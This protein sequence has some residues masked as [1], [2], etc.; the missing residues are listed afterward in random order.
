VIPQFQSLALAQGPVAAYRWPGPAGAPELHFAHA[1]G[2]NAFTYRHLL[3][4]LADE[5]SVVATD[6]RGHGVTALPAVPGAL[7]SWTLYASDLI[8]V[9]ERLGP[10]PRILVG[11]SLG[12]VISLFS[13]AT[14]PD[15]A[16]AVIM[17][18]PVTTTR[19]MRVLWRLLR[20]I[21]LL[22]PSPLTQNTLRRRVIWNSKD[23]AFAAYRGR[24]AFRTWPEEMLRDYVE[25]GLVEDKDGQLRLACSPE[26]EAANYRLGP[27]PIL[28]ALPRVKCPVTILHGTRASTV[29]PPIL[30]EIRRRHKGVRLIE[31]PRASHFLPMEAPEL[32]RGEIRRVAASVKPTVQL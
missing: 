24:G 28:D 16:S 17:I 26:W 21:G 18:E 27:P 13:A 15:L 7:K 3:A 10:T 12:A 2:F 1:N 6:F 9:L 22:G 23:E 19:R 11:H 5:M 29:F 8:D 14:R 25:A 31:V 32:V 4:P 20:P 30:S